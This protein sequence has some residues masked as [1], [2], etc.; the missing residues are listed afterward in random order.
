M[1]FGKL[2]RGI[3]PDWKKPGIGGIPWW[4]GFSTLS[5]VAQVQSQVGELRLVA[6]KKFFLIKKKTKSW[7]VA[8][9]SF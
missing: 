5:V 1:N 2:W 8:E 4:L 7:E 9:F 6:K 3:Q